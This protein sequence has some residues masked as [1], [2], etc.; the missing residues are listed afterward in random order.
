MSLMSTLKDIFIYP[1]RASVKTERHGENDCWGIGAGLLSQS[2]R[3]LSAGVGFSISFEESIEKKYGCRV[4]LLDPSETGKNTIIRKAET[5]SKNIEFLPY[6]LAGKSGYVEFGAPDRETEGSFKSYN[7]TGDLF[8]FECFSAKSLMERYGFK[9]LDLLK[10]DVEGFEY[11]I[12]K[13]LFVSKIFPKQICLEIHTNKSISI[14]QGV[15]SAAVLILRM[16]FSGYKIIYNKAMDF[17]FL[18]TL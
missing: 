1:L 2:S 15:F 13:S 5:L 16:Y 4:V 12:I 18:R 14:D 6:G 17:T 9:E 3:V 7:G 8:S 11:E 10:L